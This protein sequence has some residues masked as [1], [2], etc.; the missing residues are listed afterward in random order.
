VALLVVPEEFIE[1]W[2]W[3]NIFAK[4]NSGIG[5]RKYCGL[6]AAAIKH[7]YTC[8]QVGSQCNYSTPEGG[9][10]CEELACK[11]QLQG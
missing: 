4:E 2:R 3:E 10:G 6:F 9:K 1:M 5:C 11:P 8:W 7:V